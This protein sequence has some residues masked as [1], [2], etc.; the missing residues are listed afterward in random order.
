MVFEDEWVQQNMPISVCQN[1]SQWNKQG[2]FSEITGRQAP[3]Y[4]D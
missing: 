1:M 2:L 4:L 3:T